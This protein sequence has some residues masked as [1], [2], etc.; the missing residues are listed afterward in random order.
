MR[1]ANRTKIANQS[2]LRGGEEPDLSR[3]AQ[4]NQCLYKEERRQE[5]RCQS[6]KKGAG[7]RTFRPLPEAEKGK[8]TGFLV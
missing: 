3:W 2:T 4:C 7:S 1:V 8:V 6:E 5:S